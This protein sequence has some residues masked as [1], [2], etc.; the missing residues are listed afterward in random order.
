MSSTARKKLVAVVL[1]AVVM[2][3]AGVA[4]VTSQTAG[5]E[6]A[7]CAH[8]YVIEQFGYHWYEAVEWQRSEAIRVCRAHP[9][10][11]NMFGPG[12]K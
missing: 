9:H 11:A 6:T 7:A 2:V 10:D 8:E 5:N 3:I 4:L 12:S 1:V